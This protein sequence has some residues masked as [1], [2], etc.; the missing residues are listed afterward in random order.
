[1]TV[2][3]LYL[4]TEMKL[5]FVCN[6][7]IA[8][9]TLRCAS[10]IKGILSQLHTEHEIA[11]LSMSAAEEQSLS[12]ADRTVRLIPLSLSA[13]SFSVLIGQEAPDVIVI[14]G[15]EKPYTLPVIRLC[16]SAGALDKTA[17]FAQG[18]ACACADHYA[19]GVPERVIRR[20]TLRDLLR[21]SN[22]RTE[23]KKMRSLADDEQ[24]AI[25]LTR[26]YIGRSTLDKA[27]LRLCS[28]TAAYYQCNDILRSCFYEGQWSFASCE[29]RRIFI[30]QYYYP[31]KGFHY[32]LRAVS[33]LRE[34]YPDIKIA[35]AGYDPIRRSVVQNELKDSSYIRY[36]KSLIRQYDLEQNIELLGELDE[37]QMKAEYL[38]ANVFVLPS[39][40]ENSPNS[41]AEAMMLGVPCIAADVGGV[42]DF[43][44][45]KK[46][47]FLYPSSS[48]QL[49]AYYLDLVFSDE[50]TAAG[51]GAAAKKRAE[52]D[53]D[54]A[55]NI[56]A[57]EQIFR[58]I[59]QKG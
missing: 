47:A 22:I 49:L 7:S 23:Q 14:F 37:E 34:K 57:L 11:L 4:E 44:D 10:W 33:I 13:E 19:E 3:D 32:L 16:E 50:Q 20:W 1:M 52:K 6:A 42:S 27:V 43:A 8:D 12:F 15:T 38:R 28:P 29:P 45:N 56:A 51:L 40:I 30:S 26:H 36:V 18:M 48:A 25:A 41:L 31:L 39:T 59:A 17:L 54:R 5:L 46:E 55:V 53:Y 2:K 35:A 58:T 9:G 24:R 21:R